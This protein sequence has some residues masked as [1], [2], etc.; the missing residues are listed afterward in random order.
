M[1]TRLIEGVPDVT[2]RIAVGNA[3]T[4]LTDVI[5][6]KDAISANNR[7]IKNI[8]QEVL[9]TVEDNVI[10]W[11][12]GVDPENTGGSSADLG[13]ELG[14]GKSLMLRGWGQ[15][16]NFKHINAVSGSV[17]VIQVTPFFSGN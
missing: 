14:V 9:I 12:M 8:A 17:G 7:D 5:L 13:H 3:A 4:A 16:K 1:I 10:R 2:T 15:I 11:A 6:Y